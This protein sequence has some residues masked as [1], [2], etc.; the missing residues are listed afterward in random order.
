LWHGFLLG[1]W[2]TDRRAGAVGNRIARQGPRRELM[3]IRWKE[4]ESVTRRPLTSRA[5]QPNRKI[6]V[7]FPAPG[8]PI[9]WLT[10]SREITELG[11]EVIPFGRK[12][13]EDGVAFDPTSAWSES[14]AGPA[15]DRGRPHRRAFLATSSSSAMVTTIG[16]RAALSGA[17]VG[18][19]PQRGGW[20]AHHKLRRD[21]CR[22]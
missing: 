12:H 1:V 16:S 8:S 3:Q 9:M 10:P 20:H 15:S 11:G 5:E 21:R 6:N 17:I 19:A 14:Y 2:R 4:R 22:Y 18:V 13:R 7:D